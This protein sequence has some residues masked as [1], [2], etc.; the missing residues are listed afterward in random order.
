M[1]IAGRVERMYGFDLPG[2]L[3][4]QIPQETSE[5]RSEEKTEK[6]KPDLLTHIPSPIDL[7][8]N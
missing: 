5:N 4:E 1:V 3:L 2:A 7:T 8:P 6:Q